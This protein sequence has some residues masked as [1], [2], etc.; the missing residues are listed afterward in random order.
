MMRVPWPLR[1]G[2][3]V[4]L[5]LFVR[6]RVH[7]FGTFGISSTAAHGAG[8]MKLVPMLTATLHYSLF[9]ESN[10]LQMRLSFD[11]RVIDGA[12]A[13]SS[14][15][16]MDDILHNEILDELCGMGLARAA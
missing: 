1:T 2:L 8:I 6:R 5:N 11:H 4:R 14:M 3:V 13:A 15:A 9:D 12:V 16:M 10:N 7:N